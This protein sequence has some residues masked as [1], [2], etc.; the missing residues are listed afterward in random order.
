[1]KEFA[2][3]LIRPFAKLF[4]SL[5]PPSLLAKAIQS[6]SAEKQIVIKS[7]LSPKCKLDYPSKEIW[8]SLE[9]EYEFQTRRRSCFK[10]PETIKWIEDNLSDGDVFYDIGANIGAYSLVAS[11]LGKLNSRII[12]FEPAFMN[13][14]QLVKNLVLNKCENVSAYQL[15]LSD[16]N[17]VIEFGYRGLTAGLG[18]HTVGVRNSEEIAY[19]QNV[20]SVKMDAL[21]SLWGIPKP[22][23]IKL[24]VDGPELE[25]LLGAK[26]CL[27]SS[28]LKSILVELDEKDEF[29]FQKIT[30]LL[31]EIGFEVEARHGRSGGRH[32]NYIFRRQLRIQNAKPAS[33]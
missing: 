32:F 14:P 20:L 4:A 21:E 1:M 9:S 27:S 5:V 25:V 16:K 19:T 6:L 8:L 31:N 23:L 26:E 18:L 24:D 17:S 15:A 2:K 22:T 12:S 28:K 13:Y 7:R 33:A 11:K 3:L 29:R 30:N 10:E